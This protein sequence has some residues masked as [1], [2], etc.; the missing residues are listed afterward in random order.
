MEDQ[1]SLSLYEMAAD[2]V[3][4]RAFADEGLEPER[5]AEVDALIDSTLTGLLPAKVENYCGLIRSL[6]LEAEAFKAEEDRLAGR[7]STLEKL[8]VRLTERLQGGLESAN[9]EKLKAGIFTVAIQASPP[10]LA[11]ADGAEIPDGYYVKQEPKLDRRALLAAVKAGV[12]YEGV[13]IVQ[14]KHLRI[15]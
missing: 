4:L 14:G 13:R 12:Q 7:R 15:R 6:K 3:A 9:V 5:M 1:M 8:S 11:V 2:L 10:S